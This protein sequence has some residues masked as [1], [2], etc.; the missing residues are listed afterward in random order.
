MARARA[1]ARTA[2][3]TPA[4]ASKSARTRERIVAAAKE[5]FEEQGFLEARITDI[6]ERAG[7]SHGSFYY[8]FDSK[9]EVFREVAAALDEQLFAPLDDVI[10]AQSPLPPPQ[11]IR[12]AMRR[13]FES[14]RKEARILGLIE[15]VSRYDPEVNALR[16]RRHQ[17]YTER[18]AETL[19]QLQRRKL[20][21]P[22]LD[23]MITAAALGALTY[24]F[25]EMWLV[26]KAIDCTFEHA[27]EQCSR[28]F[29]NAVR[30]K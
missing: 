3:V 28:I 5:I 27:V 24:R 25:A 16:L 10:L 19:R 17:R 20:A 4:R 26:H 29:E 22:K 8:Y 9:E 18:V 23:P 14:Y 6:S 7:Q 15:H 1:S 21:D 30:L 11:R 2:P 12:E 13:H